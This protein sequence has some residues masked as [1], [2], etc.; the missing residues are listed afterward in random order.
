MSAHDQLAANLENWSKL[1]VIFLRRRSDSHS[2]DGHSSE[3]L[4]QCDRNSPSNSLSRLSN[5]STG[6]RKLSGLIALFTNNAAFT[7]TTLT[8]QPFQGNREH[9][10]VARQHDPPKKFIIR[11][12]TA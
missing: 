11:P 3:H 4:G 2:I 5:T 12:I 10:K 1:F 6:L 9:N 8:E 7:R